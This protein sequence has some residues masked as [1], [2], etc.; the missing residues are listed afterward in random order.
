MFRII[1]NGQEKSGFEDALKYIGGKNFDGKMLEVV[2]YNMMEPTDGVKVEAIAENVL[3]VTFNQWG[4]WF[5]RNGVGAGSGYENEYY[6]IDFKGHWYE[7]EFKKDRKD[8]TIIYQ[9]G[10]I[11]KQFEF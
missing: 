2:Q 4:N 11:W 6:K 8:F 3:K 7:L 9:D 10:A 1:N 5:W